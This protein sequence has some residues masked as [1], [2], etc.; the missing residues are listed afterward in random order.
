[1]NKTSESAIGFDPNMKITAKAWVTAHVE[2][3]A[4]TAD[5]MTYLKD[6]AE[7]VF[8]GFHNNDGRVIDWEM[9]FFRVEQHT[10]LDLGCQW[11]APHMIDL[12]KHIRKY[13]KS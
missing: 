8:D 12:K 5:Q 7:A 6:T 11:D 9:L 2:D 3:V 1:M 4:F 13:A 10:D